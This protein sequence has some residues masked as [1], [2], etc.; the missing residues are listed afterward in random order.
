VAVVLG[1]EITIVPREVWDRSQPTGKAD[2]QNLAWQQMTAAQRYAEWARHMGELG[3]AMEDFGDDRVLDVGCGPTGI[4]YFL[5]AAARVGLDPMGDLY[6]QWN[7]YYGEP[8][9]L[10]TS[11]AEH[12][13]FD[14]DSFD[15]VFCINC[16]DHTQDADSVIE[17]I[18]RVLRPSGR[19]VFHVDLDSPLRRLHKRV[20]KNCR[21]LHPLSLRYDW[22][23]GAL[24]PSFEIEREHRDP[25]PFRAA[26]A[27]MRYEAYWDGLIYRLTGSRTWMNHIWLTAR[28]R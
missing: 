4:V 8:I 3:L 2:W 23:R 27:N 13:P 24:E 17:E 5:D 28:R 25:E 14:N 16:L 11:Q 20:K 22:L 10:V 6:A 19:L 7:G 21:D 18:A 12:M 26:K 1:Q 9:D 15:S